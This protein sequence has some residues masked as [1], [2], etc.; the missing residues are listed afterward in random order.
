MVRGGARVVEQAVLGRT[1]WIARVPP[2]VEEEDGVART[3]QRCRQRRAVRAIAGVAVRDEHRWPRQRAT[4]RNEPCAETQAVARRELDVFGAGDRLRRGSHRT[5]GWEI[6]E[7]PLGPPRRGQSDDRGEQED[8]HDF[9]HPGQSSPTLAH[10]ENPA[11]GPRVWRRSLT[12][13][14]AAVLLG[15]RGQGSTLDPAGP[16]AARIAD[17]A[18]L[19][20]GIS[21]L[22]VVLVAAILAVA[23]VRRSR[24]ALWPEGRISD[25]ALIVGGGI[26]LRSEE[27]TSELQSPCNLVCRLLLEKKKQSKTRVDTNSTT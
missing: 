2:V 6:H 27:H 21:T 11:A 8:E 12:A 16:Y 10:G 9:G 5:A 19:M 15:C 23:I 3:R 24:P 22:I 18:W 20:T 4:T 7:A 13:A 17:L 25:S 26:L 14:A 1:P